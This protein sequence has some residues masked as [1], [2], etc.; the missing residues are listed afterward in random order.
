MYQG[1][2]RLCTK[3][4]PNRPLFCAIRKVR[5]SART[6]LAFFITSR[7]HA[8]VHPEPLWEVYQRRSCGERPFT[9]YS[10]VIR[11][12]PCL[13]FIHSIQGNKDAPF[14]V[15]IRDIQHPQGFCRLH[16]C[17]LLPI[18]ILATSSQYTTIEHTEIASVVLKHIGDWYNSTEEK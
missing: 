17:S 6:S 3:S 16:L 9:L 15:L 12:Y 14:H 13:L 4:P 11:L 7:E 8:P 1:C 10:P 5:W 18:G 2:E